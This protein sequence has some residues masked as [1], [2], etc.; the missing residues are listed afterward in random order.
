MNIAERDTSSAPHTMFAAE[1]GFIVSSQT[2]KKETTTDKRMFCT[3]KYSLGGLKVNVPYYGGGVDLQT[4]NPHGV[5]VPP[6]KG[7]M[8]VILFIRGKMESPFA[9]VP[10]AHPEDYKDINKYYKLIDVDDIMIAHFSGSQILFKKDGTI[11][12]SKKIDDETFSITVKFESSNK[13]KTITDDDTPANKITMS[14]EGIGIR[15]SD[16][17]VARVDDTVQLALGALDIQTLAASL[18][19]TGAFYPSGSPP[20]PGTPVTFTDGKITSGNDKVKTD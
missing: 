10:I 2:S 15:G 14:T 7:Q 6:R 4:K 11:K 19:A 20:A 13:K 12:I 9:A 16:K 1:I 3:V 5:F 17:K 8:V 18:L